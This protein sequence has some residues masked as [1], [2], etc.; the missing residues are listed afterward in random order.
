MNNLPTAA[1]VTG[2]AGTLGQEIARN[3]LS[4][5]AK[6]I[7]ADLDRERLRATQ[8]RLG[9]PEGLSALTLDVASEESWNEALE[10]AESRLGPIALLCNNAAVASDR[11]SVTAMS[12]DAWLRALAVNLTGVFLGART[13]LPGMIARDGGYLLNVASIG[14]MLSQ[15]GRGEYCAAKAGVISLSETLAAELDGT[16]VRVSVLCPGAIGH[17]VGHVFRQGQASAAPGRLDPAIAVQRAIDAMLAG[18]FYLFTE[19]DRR[20]LVAE[21]HGRILAGFERLD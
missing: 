2:G 21:R 17:P 14:G 20:D 11:Q 9:N 10:E 13:F 7:I 3:L 6:V 5:G 1:L 18:H 16:G 4:R 12:V 15:P 8:E 19:A